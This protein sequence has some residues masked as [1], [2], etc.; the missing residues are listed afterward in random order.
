MFAFIKVTSQSSLLTELKWSSPCTELNCTK[1][2]IKKLTVTAELFK[3]A[4]RKKKLER[5]LL[6]KAVFVKAIGQNS[7]QLPAKTVWRHN[8]GKKSTQNN[9]FL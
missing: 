8:V 7:S 5:E 2:W 6:L 1:S 4:F 3:A 9:L